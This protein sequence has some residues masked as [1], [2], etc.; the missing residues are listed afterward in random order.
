[1]NQTSGSNSH[2]YIGEWRSR[3]IQTNTSHICVALNVSTPGYANIKDKNFT[4]D[5]KEKLYVK[6]ELL[7]GNTAAETPATSKTVLDANFTSGPSRMTLLSD[8]FLG[9]QWTTAAT[10]AQ[11]V[12]YLSSG[13]IISD[14]NVQQGNCV[15]RVGGK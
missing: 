4:S 8:V 9:D 6:I 7:L 12:V 15:Q 2:I 10:M 3:V 5:S 13:V 14:V 11:I 1:M